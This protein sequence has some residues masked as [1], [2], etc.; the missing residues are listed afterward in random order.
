MEPEQPSPSP[1]V[2]AE[3]EPLPDREDVIFDVL[4]VC[5]AIGLVLLAIAV[6]ANMKRER[7]RN[8]AKKKGSAEVRERVAPA[9]ADLEAVEALAGVEGLTAAAALEA[10]ASTRCMERLAGRHKKLKL[11]AIYHALEQLPP[12]MW[13]A[14]E[15]TTEPSAG[16]SLLLL[17]YQMYNE[18]EL[19]RGV[20]LDERT[21]AAHTEAVALGVQ[22]AVHAFEHACKAGTGPI[23][24]TLGRLVACLRLGLWSWDDAPAVALMRQRL[25]AQDAPYP[26]IKLSA[27][28][29][30]W[31]GMPVISPSTTVSVTIKLE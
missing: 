2:L 16:Q 15:R 12:A 4:A 13:G 25:K 11:Q 29:K 5:I 20:E 23:A 9:K 18:A 28:A 19:L 1:E 14:L 22:L 30:S 26:K 21:A 6:R 24:Q 17:L 10:I 3:P 8:M 31:M 27:T 7:L